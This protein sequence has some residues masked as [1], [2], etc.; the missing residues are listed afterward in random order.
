MS[1]VFPGS[2]GRSK[3]K[4][5][6]AC[7][8]GGEGKTT[9]AKQL[10]EDLKGLSDLSTFE[11]YG[12]TQS[13]FIHGRYGCALVAFESRHRLNRFNQGTASYNQQIPS[14]EVAE[15]RQALQVNC[16]HRALPL[17]S[18]PCLLQHRQ[19]KQGQ[20]SDVSMRQMLDSGPENHS[21]GFVLTGR[22]L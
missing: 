12:P 16:R 22:D 5:Q 13:R 2:K 14:V 4:R 20:E 9:S 8:D 3:L 11:G 18:L 10:C 1:A 7:E 15:L 17:S 6:T 19:L 21:E